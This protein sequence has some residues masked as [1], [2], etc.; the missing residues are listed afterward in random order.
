MGA[1]VPATVPVVVPAGLVSSHHLATITETQLA[2][3]Q[4]A[5][6]VMDDLIK[7]DSVDFLEHN[8]MHKS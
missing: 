8:P 5:P 3:V 2:L 1:V 6:E 4:A 7:V